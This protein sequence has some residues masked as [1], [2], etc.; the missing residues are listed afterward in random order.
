MKTLTCS[1]LDKQLCISNLN[2]KYKDYESCRIKKETLIFAGFTIKNKK[3]FSII[4]N[5]IKI[6]QDV[7]SSGEI[8]DT[9]E[10]YASP[11]E[12]YFI[13]G[14]FDFTLEE[15]KYNIIELKYPEGCVLCI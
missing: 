10:L 8:L 6:E 9:K 2:T 7:Y 1:Y 15:G 12:D 3:L 13:I 14:D 4:V 5:L 11:Y